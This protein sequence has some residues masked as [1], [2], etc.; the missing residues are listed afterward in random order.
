MTT[1]RVHHLNECG[2]CLNAMYEDFE[3]GRLQR[4]AGGHGEVAWHETHW[5]RSQEQQRIEARDNRRILACVPIGIG[6]AGVI[7]QFFMH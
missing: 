4:R 1:V 6:V 5:L 7:H 2:C 3:H